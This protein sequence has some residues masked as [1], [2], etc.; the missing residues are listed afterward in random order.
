MKRDVFWLCLREPED[1]DNHNHVC[2]SIILEVSDNFPTS[3]E[4]IR[5][6][7]PAQASAWEDE[8]H[9]IVSKAAKKIRKAFK[10]CFADVDMSVRIVNHGNV[11]KLRTLSGYTFTLELSDDLVLKYQ[12]ELDEEGL[13]KDGNYDPDY[14]DPAQQALYDAEVEIEDILMDIT[15]KEMEE[16]C[17]EFALTKVI[18]RCFPELKDKQSAYSRLLE[19]ISSIIQEK[20]RPFKYRH[21]PK[22]IC[23]SIDDEEGDQDEISTS[24]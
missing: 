13:D 15:P 20:F 12:D 19:E 10:E 21:L 16:L 8:Y 23:L 14:V 2:R 18:S 17:S 5:Q 4:K 7:Y 9:E 11:L 22:A 24:G 3:W 6:T 1:T